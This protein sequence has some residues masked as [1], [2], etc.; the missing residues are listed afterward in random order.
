[1]R[2]GFWRGDL[3]E[4]D[5]SEDVVVDGRIILKLVLQW[6]RSWTGLVWLGI[7]TGGGSCD[8]G[9]EASCFKTLGEFLDYVWT[10]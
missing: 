9:I 10:R 1:V 4:R 8:Y 6:D 3:S 5:H 7:G 2:T